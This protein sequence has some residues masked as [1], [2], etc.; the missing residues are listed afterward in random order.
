MTVQTAAKVA[1]Q[2]HSVRPML[3]PMLGR[4]RQPFR[5][6][7]RAARGFTLIELMVVVAI[8]GILAALAVYGIRR[9]QQYAG[10]SEPIS[11][12]Q[13]IRVAEEAW[14]TENLAYGACQSGSPSPSNFTNIDDTSLYPRQ[15]SALSAAGA[16]EKKVAWGSGFSD[17]NVNLCFKALGVRSDGPVR[18]SYGISAGAPAAAP[19]TVGTPAGVGAWQQP[20]P[21]FTPNEV[22]F[23][24]VAVGNRDNDAIYA[25]L[26]TTSLQNE[27]YI[28]DG[29]E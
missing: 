15:F 12:L 24:A 1:R 19:V 21:A 11:M 13:N 17:G 7:R 28:E 14:K 29:T 2:M 9:Y 16:G 4:T 27:V 3:G 5:S 6:S 8:I 10:T 18:F 25:K 23:A 22:W 20:I 26:S